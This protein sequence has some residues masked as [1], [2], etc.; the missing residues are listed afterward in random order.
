VKGA[1]SID[2]AVS[3]FYENPDKYSANPVPSMPD[4]VIHARDTKDTQDTQKAKDTK[5]AKEAKMDEEH[6][7]PYAPP[8]R[9]TNGARRH[10]VHMNAVIQAANVRARDEVRY[11]LT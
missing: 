10:P 2:E 8:V 11:T 1:S 3:H 6:P 5:G 7:P 4:P 9:A